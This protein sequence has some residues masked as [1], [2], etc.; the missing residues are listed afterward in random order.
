MTPAEKERLYRSTRR[1]KYAALQRAYYQ[2]HREKV[3][4]YDRMRK[5]RDAD[6]YREREIKR[7][8]GM[9]AADFAALHAAQ[10]GA[11]GICRT[12]L[13]TE[14][15]GTVVDHCHDTGKVRGLL[16]QGCNRGIGLLKDSA[17]VLASAIAYLNGS[18][19]WSAP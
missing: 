10:G 12:T 4:A 14:N 1:E 2:R 18:P 17:E 15:R 3:L 8:Y 13:T 16:C 11:C 5:V 9:T 6:K 19:I 7:K